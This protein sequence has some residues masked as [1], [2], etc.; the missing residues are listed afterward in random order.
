VK[1]TPTAFIVG[2]MHCKCKKCKFCCDGELIRCVKRK[3]EAVK[4]IS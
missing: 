1:K 3:V 2:F 4:K